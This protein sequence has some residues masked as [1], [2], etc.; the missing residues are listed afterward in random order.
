MQRTFVPTVIIAFGLSLCES[1]AVAGVEPVK[2]APV[3][4]PGCAFQDIDLK[5]YGY[6]PFQNP[7]DIRSKDGVLDTSINVQYT[8]PNTTSIAG[9]PVKL[10]TYNGELVGP[11]LRVRQ[12]DVINLLLKNELPRESAD[13]VQAQF[14]QE[15]KNAYLD[16]I[17][18]SFNT[19]N[20]H[21]HGLHVSPTG[22]SDNVLLNIEPQKQF[23]YE[24]KLPTDHPI[25]S[26]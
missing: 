21:Y 12:G 14:E 25:G 13:E 8:D 6:A 7:P 3:V 20:I 9:C 15:N 10:R 18:A 16:T 23:P 26:Y 22:N 4:I 2:P 24:V 19:T 1:M 17:P 5:K 11:T